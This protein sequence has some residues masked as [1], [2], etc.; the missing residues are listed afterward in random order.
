MSARLVTTLA[1][2]YADCAHVREVGLESATD[3]AV[4]DFAAR[5][6]FTIVSKDADFR[7]RSFLFGHPPKTIWIRLGNCSTEQ[8]ADLLRRRSEHVSQFISASGQSFL[9]LG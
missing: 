5:E 4:W 7:Q 3:A 2:I 1:D 8:I 9:S 6:G